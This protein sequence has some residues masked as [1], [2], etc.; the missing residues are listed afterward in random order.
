MKVE[1][2]RTSCPRGTASSP[3]WFGSSGTAYF[4]RGFWEPR[5][6][7]PSDATFTLRDGAYTV[8]WSTRLTALR[9]LSADEQKPLLDRA[10]FFAPRW[11]HK[12]YALMRDTTGR[13]YYVDEPRDAE[14]SPRFR[15]F[16][17]VKG[18]GTMKPQKLVNVVSDSAGD[19]FATPN[20]SLRLVLDQADASWNAGA[21]TTV[22]I[23]LPLEASQ[24]LI[25]TDLGV[26]AGE[27]LGTPCD[28]L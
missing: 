26:Y 9:P 8:A 25:Y 12:A 18:K 11:K 4:S 22:L 17:G 20:G 15:L 14:Q 2:A 13:Y 27:R 3:R 16:V 1:S 10:K 6:Q 19:V 23:V 24:A 28:D 5:A 21:K 7:N